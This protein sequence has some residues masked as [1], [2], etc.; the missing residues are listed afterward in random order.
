MLSICIL[1]IQSPLKCLPGSITGHS[2]IWF[3]GG[4]KV[5]TLS[6]SW[7][8]CCCHPVLKLGGSCHC[9]TCWCVLV[10]PQPGQGGSSEWLG[11]GVPRTC[12]H[13]LLQQEWIQPWKELIHSQKA[14]D[15]FPGFVGITA[16]PP[17]AE[18]ACSWRPWKHLLGSGVTS[19]RY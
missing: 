15:T 16:K 6:C 10:S 7:K 19:F 2:D 9:W 1:Q 14:G 3:W 11:V 17:K 5:L 12:V 13:S 18:M 8:K 4:G